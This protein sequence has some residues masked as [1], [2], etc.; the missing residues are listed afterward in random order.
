MVRHVA[1]RSPGIQRKVVKLA[2]VA[3]DSSSVPVW[4]S[5]H[6]FLLRGSS[7]VTLRGR[8]PE[9]VFS[10]G[11]LLPELGRLGDPRTVERVGC[12]WGWEQ[13]AELAS[14]RR[15]VDGEPAGTVLG[16][17][18]RLDVDVRG[19]LDGALHVAVD[20][21]EATPERLE[22][23]AAGQGAA[24]PAWLVEHFARHEGRTLVDWLG[25]RG[26]LDY[27]GE[28]GSPF[29]PVHS[30]RPR[31]RLGKVLRLLERAA[32]G[33]QRVPAALQADLL[34]FAN[35][36]APPVRW[37]R[38]R[39]A[40]GRPAFAHDPAGGP[41]R[42]VLLDRAA[43]EAAQLAEQRPRLVRCRLCGRVFVPRRQSRPE[44]HC[45]A[46]VWLH[47]PP[48]THLEFCLPLAAGEERDRSRRRLQKRVERTLVRH[49]GDRKHPEVRRAVDELNRFAA[50]HPAARGRPRG[51]GEPPPVP[52]GHEG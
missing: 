13:L 48:H 49:G 3:P 42:S 24:V 32:G 51:T 39:L 6:V 52:D 10:V 23:A 8:A 45:H 11:L 28:D 2:T 47:R 44:A 16:D 50:E 12:R 27:T 29:R 43:I 20:E 30:R 1:S 38:L 41:V 19:G 40:D 34:A 18:L 46:G 31:A 14:H 9:L 7:S 26:I 33:G 5:P 15:R 21:L 35:A 4:E 25:V 37:R 36:V 22:D 17:H